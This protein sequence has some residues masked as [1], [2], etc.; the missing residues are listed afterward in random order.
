MHIKVLVVICIELTLLI[1][2]F[3]RYQILPFVDTIQARMNNRLS[4][5]A[6]LEGPLTCQLLITKQEYTKE[7][8]PMNT[9]N[10]N[11]RYLIGVQSLNFICNTVG[12]PSLYSKPQA[13]KERVDY[14]INNN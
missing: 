6:I 12:A 9:H 8:T 7:K 10:F 4:A 13:L 3:T 14:T 1:N 5:K 11:G 2:N